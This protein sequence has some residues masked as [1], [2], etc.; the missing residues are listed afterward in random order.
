MVLFDSSVRPTQDVPTDACLWV[1]DQT[2]ASNRGRVDASDRP[3]KLEPPVQ[4]SIFRFVEFPPA[5]AFANLSA[6]EVERI[7]AGLF[8]QL[9]ASHARIDTTRGPGMHRTRTLDYIVLLKGE[10]TL[11]LDEGDVDLKPFD[12]VVQRGTNH[13]WVN[14]GSTPALLAIAMIDAEPIS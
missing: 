4:G 7:M 9:G 12:V 10:I 3:V 1:T 6:E 8:Q 11:M 13:G 14:R 5:A 2:P